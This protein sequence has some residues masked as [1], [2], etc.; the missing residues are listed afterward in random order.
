MEGLPAQAKGLIIVVLGVLV[1]TP[2]TLLIRLIAVDHWTLLV[3]RGLLQALGLSVLVGCFHGRDTLACFRAVGLAG[4]SAAFLFAL[5]TVLFVVALSYTSVANTL[6]IVAS[7]PFFAA[8]ASR[9]FLGERIALRTWIAIVVALGGIVL[10]AFESLGTGTL[11]GDLAALGVAIAMGGNFT[12]LRHARAVNM[13]PAMALSGLIVA[14]A[15]A[16]I[17]PAA[18]VL[19]EAQLAFMLA[20]GLFVVP[21]SFALITLGPRYLPAA[22]VSLLMLLETVLGPLWVWLAIGEAPGPL[23]FLGGSVV[24]ATLAAHSALALRGEPAAQPG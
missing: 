2:D 20:M 12:V 10:L 14:L 1:L 16:P 4:Y 13:I 7:A 6:I 9:V 11:W 5:G 17:A 23:G 19:N 3:W 22:E 8:L 15:A 21:V 24:V 18:V